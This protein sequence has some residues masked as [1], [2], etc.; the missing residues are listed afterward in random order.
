MVFALLALGVLCVGFGLV[1]GNLAGNVMAPAASGLLHP[2]VY[3]TGML[4]ATG[5]PLPLLHVH[6]SFV[7]L[8]G[9]LST[10]I[11]LV[12]GG[13]L[14]TR[15]VRR[16][17]VR[18]VESLRALHTGSVND[19]ATYAAIGIVVAVAVLRFGWHP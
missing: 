6:S 18:V 1:P 16:G 10:S 15:Y 9:I 8:E 3:A 2:G 4:R 13:L 11:T 12:V 7:S 19:Y 14:A 5:A 17:P